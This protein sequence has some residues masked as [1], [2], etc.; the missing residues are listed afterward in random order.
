M[1]N[2]KDLSFKS[3]Q[4]IYCI[5]SSCV[6]LTEIV[7]FKTYLFCSLCNSFLLWDVKMLPAGGADV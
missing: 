6:K 2:N 1:M 7:Y 4:Y 3:D 5:F